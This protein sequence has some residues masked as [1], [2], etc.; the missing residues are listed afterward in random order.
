M[1]SEWRHIPPILIKA[2][3]HRNR[4]QEY[5]LKKEPIGFHQEMQI[6]SDYQS[7]IT[8]FF[9][10]I[11]KIGKNNSRKL[12]LL[13]EFLKFF[14]KFKTG[15]YVKERLSIS[16]CAKYQVHIFK[17][18]LSF[19]ILDVKN[20]NFKL[21]RRMSAFSLFD[22]LSDLGRLKCYLCFFLRC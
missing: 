8:D 1:T 11:L 3:V 21:L 17:K 10:E 22:I 7:I 19:A 15:I 4:R 20:V 14:F 6:E 13:T 2:R 9:V 12:K 16:M 5:S 18:R